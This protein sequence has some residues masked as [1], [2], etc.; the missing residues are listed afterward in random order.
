[1]SGF[2]PEEPDNVLLEFLA[3]AVLESLDNQANLQEPAVQLM[4]VHAAK[5]LEFKVVF[6]VGLEE[7][8]FPHDNSLDTQKNLEEERRFFMPSNLS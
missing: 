3:H 2:V 4:T 5:G 1:M 8:L 7:G 6:V